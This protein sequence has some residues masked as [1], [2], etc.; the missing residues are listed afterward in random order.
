MKLAAFAGMAAAA[1]FLIT[2]CVADAPSP[3]DG[4]TRIASIE[5]ASP[6]TSID[7]YVEI[8]GTDPA[9]VRLYHI[10]ADLAV[11]AEAAIDNA[12]GALGPWA[13]GSR[14][15]WNYEAVGSWARGES[16]RLHVRPAGRSHPFGN[17]AGERHGRRPLRLAPCHPYRRRRIMAGYV[18]GTISVTNGS[19]TINGVGLDFV[20][21]V[22]AGWI[23]V[24]PDGLSYEIT[25]I[26]SATQVKVRPNYRGA[27]AAGQAYFIFPTQGALIPLYQSVNALI[28]SFSAVRDGIGSGLLPD[29]TA[30]A[31]ALRFGADTDSGL[32]R[33][34]NNALGFATGGAE[35]MRITTVGLG[36][37]GGGAL[38]SPFCNLES[39]AAADSVA[40][41]VGAANGAG[42]VGLDLFGSINTLPGNRARGYIG[43]GT[44]A[45]GN[46]G[47]L[48]IAPRSSVAARIRFLTGVGGATDSVIIDAT[49]NMSV[50]TGS[51]VVGN[52]PAS[53][54]TRLEI[55]DTASTGTFVR[56]SNRGALG[57]YEFILRF[58]SYYDASA[59]FRYADIAYDPVAQALKFRIPQTTERFR[60]ETGG[61]VRPGADNTQTLGS[62]SFRWSVI[63]AGT[64]TINTSDAR[65]KLWRG[66]ADAAELRAAKRIAAELGFYQWLAKIDEIGVENARF[67]FGVRAQAVWAIMAD[68]GLVDPLDEDGKPG[69][70]PYAFL[71]WDEWPEVVEDVMA[72]VEIPAVI[73]EATGE[74]IEP[75]RTEMQP[76]GDT[77]VTREAGN[78]FGIRPDQLALFLTAGHNEQIEAQQAQIDELAATVAALQA[79]AGEA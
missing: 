61:A 54:Q 2:G 20:A 21:N 29:G 79:G 64:G 28:S 74:E 33:I 59:T 35:R 73:N 46:A 49:G 18:A 76:T 45:I 71:C 36:L 69:T 27:T 66:A 43:M 32:Y 55:S 22:I 38:F 34:G 15:R 12:N 11:L 47:D 31:P 4:P 6:A 44:A 67:H 52:A 24:G 50:L 58:Q 56:I 53:T 41:A 40:I 9:V 16:A 39:I 48:L 25:S 37:S 10:P 13:A 7:A 42:S 70:T 57:G 5:I 78:R 3:I 77:V 1:L 75:A 23:L 19:D 30:A 68:E 51:L 62:A 14:A 8:N 26:P 65:D 63:Y 60:L 17:R 72:P